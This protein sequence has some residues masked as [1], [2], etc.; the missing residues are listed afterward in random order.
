MVKRRGFLGFAA[1]GLAAPAAA[2]VLPRPAL[3]Q[4][5]WPTR[6]VRLIVGWPPGGSVDTIARILQPRWQ[7]ALGQ[8]LVIDNK[9]GASGSIGAAEA[10]RAAP[11]GYTWLLAYDTTATNETVMRLPYKTPEAFAPVSLVATGPL[12]MVAHKDTPYHSF[13]D[14]VEDARR[15]P[16]GAGRH[17]R[18]RSAVHVERRRDQPA[19]EIGRAAPAR[20]HHARRNAARP[21]R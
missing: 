19:H 15:R 17:R 16:G 4:A 5:N 9:G 13:R 1:T 3:A 14:V 2:T 21:R 18:P 10:A 8:P 6:A 20:R 11:D 7:E 12:C